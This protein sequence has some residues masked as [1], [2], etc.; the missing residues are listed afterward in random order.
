METF[1]NQGLCGLEWRCMQLKLRNPRAPWGLSLPLGA[2]WLGNEPCMAR[3]LFPA[4]I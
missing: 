2:I 3:R 1:G 4:Y